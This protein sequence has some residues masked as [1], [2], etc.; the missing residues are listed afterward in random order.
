MKSEI[1]L[2]IILACAIFVMFIT[3]S[4]VAGDRGV[5]VPSIYIPVFEPEQKAIIAWN[6]S[7]ETL[8]I[9]TNVN[10]AENSTA[11]EILPLP[12]NPCKIKAGD[13]ESFDQIQDMIGKHAPT[14][15]RSGKIVSAS[16]G[17][18][19]TFQEKIGAHS[20]TVVE[21][22]DAEEFMGWMQN[23]LMGNGIMYNSTLS[24]RLEAL[25]VNYIDRGINFFVFDLI[26][27]NT[28][29]RSVEPIVYQFETDFLYYPLEISSIAS[30]DTEISLF[31]L[32]NENTGK[33][34]VSAAGFNI[35]NYTWEWYPHI[36]PVPVEF[37]ID[38]MEIERIGAEFAEL[39]DDADDSGDGFCGWSTYGKCSSDVDCVRGGCSGQVCQSVYEERVISI[40][41]W[42]DCYNS[43]EYDL[44]CGCVDGMCQWKKEPRVWL[45]AWRYEGSIES[46]ESDFMIAASEV[47][48]ST[49]FL[50]SG[51]VNHSSGDP[52]N[53]PDVVIININISEE[54]VVETTAG[55]NYYR[56]MTS[57]D[58]VSA[59]DVIIFSVDG[60]T[61][62]THTVTSDEIDASGFGWN[63]TVPIQI[64]GDVNDDGYL[65]TA[66][67]AIVLLMTV[68]GEY[69]EVADVS[70]D[71]RVTSL[72]AL[73]ILQLKHFENHFTTKTIYADGAFTD[74]P[75]N[76]DGT[77]FKKV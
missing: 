18:N 69:S 41:V 24:T 60:G 4:P 20:I 9:S 35:V 31:T 15:S 71:H 19:I 45:T 56:V 59:G 73:M 16:S 2:R 68:R 72:D 1:L 64:P 46:F 77:R 8:I 44:Y 62:T 61:T 57:S 66:D 47:M 36:P 63:I 51:W 11:I 37:G 74:D 30:G 39:F 34:W 70:G 67:A 23:F 38:E 75:A 33:L 53:N 52:I 29:E 42:R 5:M 27:L 55:S 3:I 49:P 43:R 65:T 54:F 50:I 7:M 14:Q 6:G 32:T 26:E 22:N 40:C 21:V 10:A 58:N 12:S 28:S 17:I 76:T 48:S 25:V 13:L